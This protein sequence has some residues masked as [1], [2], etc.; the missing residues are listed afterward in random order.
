MFLSFPDVANFRRIHQIS[1]GGEADC[2]DVPDAHV[3][4]D[5][6]VST[7]RLNHLKCNNLFSDTRQSFFILSLKRT[8]TY[9]LLDSSLQTP[10]EADR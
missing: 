4:Y 7:P 10:R 8:T 1:T 5:E 2:S 6:R 9:L 3:E